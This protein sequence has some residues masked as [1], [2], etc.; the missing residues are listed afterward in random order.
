MSFNTFHGVLCGKRL[1]PLNSSKEFKVR[2]LHLV[3]RVVTVVTAIKVQYYIKTLVIK[4]LMRLISIPC[5]LPSLCVFVSS[6]IASF[7]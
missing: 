6:T 4:Q 2:P 1:F 5:A 3:L 7:V